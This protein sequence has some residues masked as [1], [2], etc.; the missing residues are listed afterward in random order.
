MEPGAR[1]P[2][3]LET[4]F[5]DAF[6]TR[7]QEALARLFEDEAI[8]VADGLVEVRGVDEIGRVATAIWAGG[9]TYLA[10]PR[11]ILQSRGTALLMADG[12]LNVARRGSDGAW[13]FAISLLA[14]TANKKEEQ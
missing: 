6:V 12:T 5:E 14:L 2:E 1:T 13:R 8:L 7:D 3:E 10:D 9:R 11:R 4:L